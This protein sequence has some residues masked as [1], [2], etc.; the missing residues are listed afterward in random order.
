MTE[1]RGAAIVTAAATTTVSGIGI[2]SAI[3]MVVEGI[4]GV[5]ITTG[6]DIARAMVMEEDGTAVREMAVIVGTT[7]RLKDADAHAHA[8]QPVS[9][10]GLL[11]PD[12]CPPPTSQRP[13][14][15]HNNNNNNNNNNKRQQPPLAR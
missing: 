5:T 1:R 2:G 8:L 6:M 7:T 9:T 13:G 11:L 14:N 10:I 15:K 3:W 4:V 12:V